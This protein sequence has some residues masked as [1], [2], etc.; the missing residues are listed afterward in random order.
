MIF[1]LGG[2]KLI[3]DPNELKKDKVLHGKSVI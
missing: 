2:K 3:I 1:S